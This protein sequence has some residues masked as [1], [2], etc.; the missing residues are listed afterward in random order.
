MGSSDLA[1]IP[2]REDA[3]PGVVRGAI[4]LVRGFGATGFTP[5]PAKLKFGNARVNILTLLRR[6]R[7][8][9]PSGE[10]GERQ[11]VLAICGGVAAIG[12]GLGFRRVG[13][14]NVLNSDAKRAHF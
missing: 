10:S 11:R 9:P 3:P 4:R 12:G 13:T 14:F 8:G 2:G 7:G 1:S 6:T 5:I